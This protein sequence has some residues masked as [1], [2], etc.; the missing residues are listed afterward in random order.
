MFDP[1][2][3]RELAQIMDK[4]AS[5]ESEYR[6]TINRAYYATHLYIKDK[7]GIGGEKQSVHQDVIS[8]LRDN[9]KAHIKKIGEQLDNLFELRKNADYKMYFVIL[10]TDS[11]KAIS[12]A[13]Y[14]LKEFD[15]LSPVDYY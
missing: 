8:V 14:I 2:K 6:T 11:G 3:F 9:K 4:D 1:L 10:D 5:Q 13:N 12:L 7:L 15:K